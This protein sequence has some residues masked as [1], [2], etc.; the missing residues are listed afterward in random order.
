MAWEIDYVTLVE[1]KDWLRINA[2]D[3]VDD[4]VLP[5]IITAASRA[6]DGQ[7]NR[8]FGLLDTPEAYEAEPWGRTARGWW[9]IDIPDLMTTTGLTVSVDGSPVA[10]EAYKL[11]PADAAWRGRPW[12]AMRVNG[13]SCGDVVVTAA[14]GW[15]AVPAGVTYAAQQQAQRW[16]SRRDSPFGIAGSPDAGSELRLLARLDPDVAVALSTLARGRRVR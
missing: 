2:D 6:V 15:S 10:A 7:C 5:T 4:A 12:E 8:S 14:F 13:G 11:L 9:E 1:L 16:A 3:A